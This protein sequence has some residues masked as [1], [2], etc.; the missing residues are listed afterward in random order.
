M[1]LSV[2]VNKLVHNY[3]SLRSQGILCKFVCFIFISESHKTH[4]S[5][6]YI[7]VGEFIVPLKE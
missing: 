7:L 1:Y 5:K 6:I 4:K 2:S 3:T